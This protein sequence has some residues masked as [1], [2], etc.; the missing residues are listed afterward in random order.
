MNRIL[1]IRFEF[2]KTFYYA[3]ILCKAK[4][5]ETEYRITVMNGD[6]EKLLCTNNMI[7]EIKGCLHVN[8]STNKLQNQIKFEVAKAFGKII[9]KPLKETEIP[10]ERTEEKI[11]EQ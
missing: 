3:L 9:G 7:R 1:V 5:D 2:S 8:F 10:K 4:A 6:I 11:E